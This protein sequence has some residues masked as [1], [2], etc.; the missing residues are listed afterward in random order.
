MDGSAEL[1]FLVIA[2][3]LRREIL[4][5][6]RQPGSRLPTEKELAARSSVSIS[7]VRRAVDNLVAEGLVLRRQGSGTYV[8]VP[9]TDRSRRVL[10]GVVVPSTT[11]YYPHVLRGIEEVRAESDARVELVCSGYDQEVETKAVREMLEAGVDGLL[12]AP[13]L[14][15]PEPTDALL[16]RLAEL[17]VPVVLIERRG[18][19]LAAANESVCTHHEAGAYHAVQHLVGLGHGTIG[20]VL[21]SP[22]PTA[23]PVA[24]GYHQ[25][26]AELGSEPV[27]FQAS[28]EEWGPATADRALAYLRSAGCTAALCFGDRQAALL[29]SAA[30]RA[31]LTVPGDLALVAYD[32]EIADIPE[33]PLTA[34]APPKY[35]I[36]RAA[37]E[38]LLHRLRH[39][40]H[41]RRSMLMRPNL[42]IRQSCGAAVPDER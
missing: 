37:T 10:V 15:G 29:V 24:S 4:D 38:L 33:V 22:S 20:L 1:K 12:L 2:D 19:S 5:G 30:R 39:P 35:L 18:T 3:R 8:R 41:P 7:T 23:D 31:A 36:G 17:P 28:L 42:T 32:D 40:G 21:R 9:Q 26:V 25:A 34:V 11:F 14:T 13:T 16:G 6:A 27:R